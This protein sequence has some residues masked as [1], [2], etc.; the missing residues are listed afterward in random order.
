MTKFPTILLAFCAA[1][2]VSAAMETRFTDSGELESIRVG[3]A[4]FAT[5]G[6]NLWEAEFLPA[7]S[8]PKGSR[9][10]FPSVAEDGWGDGTGAQQKAGNGKGGAAPQSSANPSPAPEIL[11]VAASNATAFAKSE[12]GEA[13]TLVWRGITLGGET[14]ALDATIHIAKNADGSQSWTLNFDNR[15]SKYLLLRTRFPRINR[16]TRNGEG[17][18]FLPWADHGGT[19]FKKRS[20]QPTPVWAHYLGYAPPVA[21]FFIG[22]DGLYFAAEDPEAR[23]KCFIERDEQDI[24]F[25]SCTELGAPGPGFAVTFAPLKGD[26]WEAARRYRAF[27]LRQAWAAKGPIKDNPSYPRRICEIPLWI[28]IHAYPEEAE[29]IRLRVKKAFPGFPTGIHW[30]LWQ[31]SGHDENY[32]EF[33]PARAGTAEVIAR[34]KADNQEMLPYANGRLWSTGTGGYEVARPFA[35][36]DYEGTRR[37]EI[38]HPATPPLAAMCPCCEPWQRVVRNFTSRILDEL[39]SGALFLDQIGS[40]YAVECHD[41]SHNH[42]TGGG[43]WWYDGYARMMEPIRRK[44]NARGAFVTTE[45]SGEYCLGMVDGYMQLTDRTPFDVPFWNAVYSGYTTYFCS[46]E[47]IDDDDTSFRALQTRELFWGN[48]LGW[49]LPEVLD[50]PAKCGILRELCAFRHANLD[51]LAYGTLLDELRP[52]APIPTV[53]CAWHGRRPNFGLF[54]KGFA[55][56][57]ATVCEMPSVMGNWWRTDKGETVLLAANLAGEE[58]TV[59]YRPCGAAA[60]SGQERE[61][62]LAPHEMRRIAGE[63]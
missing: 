16:V 35:V 7:A 10:M 49:F 6:G 40:M 42:T 46:P 39:G 58:R 48:A 17:D 30:H 26:W 5:G 4:V 18:A 59:R 25:D 19:L 63:S 11:T 62:T 54:D 57:P 44:A 29:K 55:L 43:T 36:L 1:S 33:F 12:T 32:P 20:A 41:P 34:A 52:A 61:I 23:Q 37:A 31:H 2:V 51:A 27:A 21:A 38:Y 60:A 50:R 8:V 3:D 15:S 53:Q 9:E 24:L 56:P 45:G 28:N 13:I 22:E 47:N 14:N